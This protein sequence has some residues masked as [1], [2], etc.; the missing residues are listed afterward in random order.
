MVDSFTYL[1][2]VVRLTIDVHYYC[3]TRNRE[4]VSRLLQ[5]VSSYQTWKVMSITLEVYGTSIAI[6]D[7]GREGRGQTETGNSFGPQSRD[8]L[9]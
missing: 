9:A 5:T 3:A 8:E 4:F 2:R 7:G 6:K 1:L